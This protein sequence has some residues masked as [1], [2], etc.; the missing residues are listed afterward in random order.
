M[1]FYQITTVINALAACGVSVLCLLNRPLSRL[2]RSFA[3]FALSV[4]FWSVSSAVLQLFFTNHAPLLFWR[5]SLLGVIAAPPAFYNFT[6]NLSGRKKKRLKLLKIFSAAAVVIAVLGFSPLLIKAAPGRLPSP[7]AAFSVIALYYLAAVIPG[8]LLVEEYHRGLS[9]LGEREIKYLSAASGAVFFG[10]ILN[11]I[12]WYGVRGASP[13]NI[14]VAA[15]IAGA[16]AVTKYSV[17]E[18]RLTLTRAGIFTCIYALVLGIPFWLGNATSRWKLSVAL[19]GV[20]ASIGP[21]VYNL[22]GRKVKNIMLSQQRRYQQM[23]IEISQS[24]GK[25]RDL[26]KLLKFIV[27]AVKRSVK[28]KFA[29]VFLYNDENRTYV[30]KAV[31]DTGRLHPKFYFSYSHP[32][33]TYLKEHKKPVTIDELPQELEGFKEIDLG[34]R[35]IVPSFSEERLVSFLLLGDKL[36][37][38][39]Y[40][41]DDIN[42]FL[43]LSGQ[44]ALAIENCMYL[45]EF[46]KTQ[47]KIFNAEKLASIGGMADGVAHQIKNRLNQFSIAAGEQKYEIEDFMNKH[48]RLIDSSPE[49]KKTFDYLCEISNSLLENVKKTAGVIQ[50]VLSFAR[51][52]E[53]STLA[54]EFPLGD[55]IKPTLELLC[56]KHQVNGF[57]LLVA[58]GDS[59]TLYGIKSQLMECLY[60]LLDN[61][62]E[63]IRE[64]MDYHPEGR[65]DFKPEIL[66]KVAKN[67]RGNILEISDNGIGIKPENMNR[68]FA[69]FFTTKSSYKT[70]SGVGMYVVKRMVEENHKGKVRVQSEYMKG[71]RVSLELPSK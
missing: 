40:S 42:I 24:M 52:E 64:K 23:L 5:I 4:A 67:E 51:V 22:L 44:A 20:L 41:E 12:F 31:K 13:G 65:G 32:L 60:N 17:T 66:L 18:I 45:R 7:G 21:F 26:D 59:K 38:T 8:L 70:G 30:L 39:N 55:I 53:Q 57:P 6:L 1:P 71:T 37:K 35:L 16:F 34:I 11:F 14:L 19:M 68:I 48:E 47:E 43:T 9:G 33:V 29:A 62:F 27:Y 69:P 50:G 49:L 36:D 10:I 2:D 28:I 63:A 3:Y 54:S 25:Q 61:A 56:V 58:P 15:G 46:E